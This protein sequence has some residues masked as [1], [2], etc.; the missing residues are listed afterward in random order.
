MECAAKQP[1]HAAAMELSG[2]C[3]Q[4]TDAVSAGIVSKADD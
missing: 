3:S 4:L 1:F 2:K